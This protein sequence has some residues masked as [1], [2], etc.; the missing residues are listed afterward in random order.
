ML[1]QGPVNM[2]IKHCV[3]SAPGVQCANNC[4]CTGR[5]AQCDRDITQ[6]AQV[7]GPA[8]RAALGTRQ[9]FRFRPGEQPQQGCRC[10]LYT[11]DAADE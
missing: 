5:I 10:L 2:L 6:P 9:E 3:Q 11:S 1:I 7:T 4:I 8:N